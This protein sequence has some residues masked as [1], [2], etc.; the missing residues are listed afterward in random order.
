M[1]PEFKTI[2][3]ERSRTYIYAD[4]STLK[5][6]NVVALAAP[7]GRSHRLI[8]AEGKKYIVVPGFLAIEVDADG[9][10]A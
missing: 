6:T 1:E 10:S 4:G 7:P 9:W 3:G 8:T 2:E 5:F